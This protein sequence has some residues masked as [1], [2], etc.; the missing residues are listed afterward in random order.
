MQTITRERQV[1]LGSKIK[2]VLLD[3]SHYDF[4]IDEPIRVNKEDGTPLLV[5]CKGAAGHTQEAIE[6]IAKFKA[7]ITNRGT[8]VGIHA[9]GGHKKINKNGMRT[10][11]VQIPWEIAK[12]SDSGIL[13]YF[14]RS[15]RYPFARETSFSQQRPK[16][17]RKF[18]PFVKSVANV[19]E[20]H[21]PQYFKIQQAIASLTPSD[22]IIKG[23]PFSS[24]T[25]NRNFQT[26][27]HK[28]AGDLAEGF[29]VM[30]YL[31]VGQVSGG[32]LVLPE[33][34]IAARLEH[35]DIVLFDVHAWHGN[36]PLIKHTLDA[37]RITC[38]FYYRENL[39]RCGDSA[40][41]LARAKRCRELGTLYDKEEI[42]RA[43]ALKKQALASLQGVCV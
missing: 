7:P 21:L 4:V 26:A 24:I 11:T 17:W 39:L 5:L 33:Y 2:G 36:T 28:D 31:S 19:F 3:K 8:A 41:E 15:A 6:A 10:K 37:Q 14:D 18:Q 16:E 12:Q 22:W 13:G 43:I 29:G 42:E 9:K 35:S 23:T 1:E 20:E 27:T 38:V 25:V 40:Y 34:R 32:Y 30:A